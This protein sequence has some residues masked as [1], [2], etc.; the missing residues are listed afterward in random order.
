MHCNNQ[1]S[2]TRLFEIHILDPQSHHQAMRALHA[3]QHRIH[4]VT[5]QHHRQARRPLRS[6]HA[7]EPGQIH[8]QHFAIQKQQSRQSLILRRRR[9]FA[10][11]R[12]MR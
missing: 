1:W 7:I 5:R 11:H 10:L 9:Y 3:R 4:L 8:L 2:Q 6:H 12:Q